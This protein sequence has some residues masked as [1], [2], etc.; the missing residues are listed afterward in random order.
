MDKLELMQK[1]EACLFEGL[2]MMDADP[3]NGEERAEKYWAEQKAAWCKTDEEREWW[4]T[5]FRY[6]NET[7]ARRM[8]GWE[9]QFGVLN[10]AFDKCG[11]P[12]EIRLQMLRVWSEWYNANWNKKKEA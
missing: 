12:K 4:D 1:A 3:I 10:A 2:D 9:Y 11:M 7:A 6:G 5:G 8:K